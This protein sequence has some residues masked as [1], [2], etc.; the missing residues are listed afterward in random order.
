MPRDEIPLFAPEKPLETDRLVLEPLRTAHAP[1]L[2]EHL[3][4]RRLYTFI[5]QDPPASPK[6]LEERYRKLST[7]R[8]PDGREAWLNWALRVRGGGYAGLLEATVEA[9]RIA[10]VAHTV[11]VPYQGTG[12]GA[13]GCRRLLRHLFEDYN[14]T[15]AVAEVDTRNA[16]SIALVEA[17]G[18][19]RVSFHKNADHFKDAPS[20]EYRYE[21]RRPRSSRC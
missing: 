3:L 17:L 20:D 8:S 7:R 12:F 13:E 10:Y 16:A 11:F 19:E 15:A 2:Y 6:V 18:F 21:L 5:P 9:D 4:D 14:V 1:K